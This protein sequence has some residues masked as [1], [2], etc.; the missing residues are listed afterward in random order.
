MNSFEEDHFD[1]A[2]EVNPIVFMTILRLRYYLMFCWHPLFLMA[3][4]L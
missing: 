3:Y 1:L 4:L 2:G